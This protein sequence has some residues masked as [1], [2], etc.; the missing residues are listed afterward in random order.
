[1][2][3]MENPL[4]SSSIE[5][6]AQQALVHEMLERIADKWTLLVIEELAQAAAE[7]RFTHLAQRL[8]GVSQKML[9][10][11]LRQLERDGLVTR[12]V[13]PVIPPHVDYALTPRGDSLGEAVCGIWIWAEKHGEQVLLSREAYDNRTRMQPSASPGASYPRMSTPKHDPAKHE[14]EDPIPD[15][16][17]ASP[18]LDHPD[19]GVFHHDPAKSAPQKP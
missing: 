13:H 16:E 2:G 7:L 18:S 4:I 9:T 6:T 8:P 10:K 17:P 19:P 1:M 5:D 14:V 12:R 11:T 15:P 3:T